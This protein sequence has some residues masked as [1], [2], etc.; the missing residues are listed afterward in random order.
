MSEWVCGMMRH[1]SWIADGS[2]IIEIEQG[3][4]LLVQCRAIESTDSGWHT[5][6]TIVSPPESSAYQLQGRSVPAGIVVHTW[7]GIE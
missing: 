4:V 2:Q 6:S 5:F 1:G 7:A 3:R